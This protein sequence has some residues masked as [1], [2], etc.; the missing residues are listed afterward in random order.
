MTKRPRAVLRAQP[1]PLW[2]Q[3]ELEAPSVVCMSKND[4]RDENEQTRAVLPVWR[5]C[6][7]GAGAGVRADRSVQQ[8]RPPVRGRQPPFLTAASAG[9]HL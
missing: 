7:A 4:R 6:W 8:A 9:Q 5:N 3:I 2:T 1:R